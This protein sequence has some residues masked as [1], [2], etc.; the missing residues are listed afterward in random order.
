MA[1]S[2]LHVEALSLPPTGNCVERAVPGAFHCCTEGVTSSETLAWIQEHR[3]KLEQHL[4]S[5]GVILFRGFGLQTTDDFDAFVTAFGEENFAYEESLSNAVRVVQTERVF[6][7]NE[8][9]SDVTIFLHH[10]MAQTPISPCKLF[11]FCEIAAT[12]GGATPVCRSDLLLERLAEEVPQFVD[13]CESKGLKYTNVMPGQDDPSSGMGRSWR[14]TLRAS[15]Q[16]EA[17]AK[18]G[19]LGYTWEWLK[20]DCLRATTPLLP[21]VREIGPGRRSFFNQLIAASKGWKDSRNDPSKA[22]TYG[23]GQPL[24]QQAVFLATEL[25]KEFTFDVAWH[26]GDVALVD[27][28]IS[29]HARQPFQGTRKIWAS[30]TGAE[31]NS[32]AD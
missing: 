4:D 13:D 26:P 29:M 7:A 10:E 5:S 1:E 23:D 20:D 32:I 25:A 28:R 18:L 2:Q 8:A 31:R 3:S 27:N 16:T 12:E 24:D 17:E 30:L 22:I 15:D 14:S 6:S 9:P 19:H 11:F 21:A